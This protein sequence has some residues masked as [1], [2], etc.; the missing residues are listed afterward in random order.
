MKYG[1]NT[2]CTRCGM[3]LYSVVGA[4]GRAAFDKAPGVRASQADNSAMKEE[5]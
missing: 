4:E 3:D 2:R 1:S 5:D